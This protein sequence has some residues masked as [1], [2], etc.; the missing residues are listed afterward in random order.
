MKGEALMDR[1]ENR[2]EAENAIRNTHNAMRA[3]RYEIH[4]TAVYAKRTQFT[5]E[6]MLR[7]HFLEKEL[8][9]R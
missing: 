4:F 2:P 9:R 3:T 8:R 6:V 7:K 5:G 1:N